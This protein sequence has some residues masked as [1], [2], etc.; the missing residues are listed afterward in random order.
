[1]LIC[2]I[3]PGE[4]ASA[5]AQPDSAGLHPHPHHWAYCHPRA[6][7]K[8]HPFFGHSMTST[9]WIFQGGVFCVLCCVVLCCAVLERKRREGESKTR[10]KIRN[11]A[12]I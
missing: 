11:S 3:L 8:R 9:C 12:E 1:M 6:T 4:I 10:I 5:H 2:D 7:R